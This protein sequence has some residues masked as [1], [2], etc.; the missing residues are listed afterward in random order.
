MVRIVT[1]HQTEDSMIPVE[2]P[3]NAPDLA[4]ESTWEL[5][6]DQLFIAP[7]VPADADEVFALLTHPDQTYVHRPPPNADV[8]RAALPRPPHDPWW[9]IRRADSGALVGRL[10]VQL[11]VDSKLIG[12]KPR[13]AELTLHLHP[14]EQGKELGLVPLVE[15]IAFLRSRAWNVE[16]RIHH[17]N[18]RS[19]R[20]A[21]K[22][23]MH[24]TNRWDD[25]GHVIWAAEPPA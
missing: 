2:S 9:V 12:G 20:L 4:V 25:V 14:D 15:C 24:E 6:T 10:E 18:G 8:V 11:F 16:G 13:V 23:G 17:T 19:P 22:A 1:Q 3:D 7:A 5:R 21:A